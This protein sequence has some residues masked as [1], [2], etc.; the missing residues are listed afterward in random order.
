MT[1][2]LSPS[3]PA[4]Q[5]YKQSLCRTR[6]LIEQTFGVLTDHEIAT[7]PTQAITY[8]VACAVLHNF[9][10]QRGDVMPNPDGNVAPTNDLV[11]NDRRNDG[12]AMRQ[13]IVNNF[14]KTFLQG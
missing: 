3:T 2:F 9:G 7:K 14:F 11:L 5:R 8:I 1:S 4:E 6:V 13:L 10:I 12:L